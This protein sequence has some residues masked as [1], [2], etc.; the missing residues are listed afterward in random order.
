M[1][2]EVEKIADEYNL[3]VGNKDMPTLLTIAIKKCYVKLWRFLLERNCYLADKH[4]KINVLY[5][6]SSLDL[7]DN[8]IKATNEYADS[9][10]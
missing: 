9:Q 5:K 3:S 10:N 7:G 1:A 2:A 8:Y 6:E 4:F